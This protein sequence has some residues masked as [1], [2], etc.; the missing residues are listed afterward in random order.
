ME[1]KRCNSGGVGGREGDGGKYEERCIGERGGGDEMEIS[2]EGRVV[3]RGGG[4]RDGDG[5][6]G[7]ERKRSVDCEV[8]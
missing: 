6:G 7:D 2:A 1:K 3:E 5:R 4:G 8:E